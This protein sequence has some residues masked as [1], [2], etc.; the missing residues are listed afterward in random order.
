MY[1]LGPPGE[2][3]VNKAYL[4]QV[5]FWQLIDILRGTFMS[6][7][8][9]DSLSLMFGGE[10]GHGLQTLGLVLCRALRTGGLHVFAVNEFMSRIRGGSNSLNLRISMHQYRLH[11][12]R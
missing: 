3:N 2:M 6:I 12:T 10:A 5:P 4:H 9:P 1:F 8:S 7:P 11:P